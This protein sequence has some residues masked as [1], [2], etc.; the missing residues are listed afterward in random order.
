MGGLPMQNQEERIRLAK[1]KLTAAERAIDAV[2]HQ[3]QIDHQ[4]FDQ[5]LVAARAARTELVAILSKPSSE[6]GS[7][8]D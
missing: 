3:K 5:L 1:E 2:L 8:T 6:C 7:F 4:Q